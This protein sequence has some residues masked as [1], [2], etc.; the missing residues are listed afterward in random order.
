MT[1]FTSAIRGILSLALALTTVSFLARASVQDDLASTVSRAL[2][3]APSNFQAFHSNSAHSDRYQILYETT[4]TLRRFCPS[5]AIADE[6]ADTDY[7][8]RWTFSFKRLVPQSWSDAQ[9]LAYMRATLSPLVPGYLLTYEEKS[10]STYFSWWRKA[11]HTFLYA[12]T[13]HDKSGRGFTVRVGHYLPHNLHVVRFSRGFTDA[14]KTE[15]TAAVQSFIR[16]GVSDAVNNFTSMRGKA[17]DNAYFYLSHSFGETL[18]SCHVRNF[19]DAET[20]KWIMSCETPDLNSSDEISEIK[21]LIR[22]AVVAVL[23]TDFN[24]TTDPTYLGL[25]DYRWD[26][27]SDVVSVNISHFAGSAFSIEIYHYLK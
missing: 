1:S 27:P 22:S 8:E 19:L 15:L 21:D 25:D 11:S 20:P 9:L 14:D 26:R 13:F 18:T 17:L 12:A 4:T 10:D 7:D 16:L 23:P 2:A 24:Q 3:A 6:Y 5:C